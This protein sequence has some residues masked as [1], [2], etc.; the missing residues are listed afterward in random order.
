MI[1][2]GKN[3]GSLIEIGLRNNNDIYLCMSI[4]DPM[5]VQ[6]HTKSCVSV[7]YVK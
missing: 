2:R 1:I 3:R 7:K 4:G 6:L 5:F